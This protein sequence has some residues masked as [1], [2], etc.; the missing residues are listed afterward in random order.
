M[1]NLRSWLENVSTYIVDTTREHIT[2]MYGRHATKLC[3]PLHSL[4][5]CRKAAPSR[6]PSRYLL[7]SLE[8][9]LP[10]SHF[11][12]P[13]STIS[14]PLIYSHA[15][16]GRRPVHIVARPALVTAPALHSIAHL[17]PHSHL[18]TLI[19]TCTT[20]FTTILLLMTCLLTWKLDL[21][22]S[23][24]LFMLTL[25]WT[26]FL[27]SNYNLDLRTWPYTVKQS[28]LGQSLFSRVALS[29]ESE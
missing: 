6:P 19:T 11:I 13:S 25:L 14:F 4:A 7:L 22:V 9:I 15:R 10:S 1:V 8:T 16:A 27:L 17:S 18:S 29:N 3:P 12:S 24:P 23:M 2:E 26:I 21:H 20:I 5:D 28:R